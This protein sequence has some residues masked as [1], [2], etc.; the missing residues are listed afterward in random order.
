MTKVYLER[1]VVTIIVSGLA[2]ALI[3]LKL[4]ERGL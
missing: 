4:L 2:G 3:A 1:M